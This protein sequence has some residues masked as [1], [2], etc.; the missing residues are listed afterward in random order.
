MENMLRVTRE[1]CFD[2]PIVWTESFAGLPERIRELSC[3]ATKICI[4]SDSTVA[5]L[6]LQEVVSVLRPEYQVD[7]FVFPAGE[8]HKNLDTVRDFYRILIEKH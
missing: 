4:A 2:Y 5:A 8:E 7:T 3:K 6:Y 1:N